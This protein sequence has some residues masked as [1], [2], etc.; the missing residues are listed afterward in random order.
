M[1]RKGNLIVI[2]DIS[3]PLTFSYHLFV[4]LGILLPAQTPVLFTDIVFFMVTM[5][6]LASKRGWPR[7]VSVAQAC[8]PA[9]H[10]HA[11]NHGRGKAIK[12]C[13]VLLA[14]SI[15][16]SYCIHKQP[17]FVYMCVQVNQF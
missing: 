4:C 10:Q 16:D 6:Q 2:A 13:C 8:P 9:A 1:V 17:T 11:A 14:F 3:A 15:Q 12:S 7:V 5:E